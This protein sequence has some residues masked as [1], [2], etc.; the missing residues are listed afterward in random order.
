M[1]QTQKI[2]NYMALVKDYSKVLDLTSPKML[3]DFPIGIERSL[4][5]AHAIPPKARVLDLGSGAGLPAIPTAIWREDITIT[6]CE[7]RQ[8]R[9]A[10]LE[11]A[12]SLLE[13]PHATVFQGDVRR[14]Q[15]HFNVVTALWVGSLS[16]I[17][18]LVSAR[19]EPNWS[20]ISRK[21]SELEKEVKLLHQINPNI[22]I[23]TQQL[24]D[25]ATLVILRGG[26]QW[27]LK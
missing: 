4:P 26:H 23:E 27:Q 9:A 18:E 20:I 25:G 17:Y 2:S 6:L 22:E 16:Q 21:G 12:V 14:L 5:I 11:R 3:M 1:N 10:F 8:K 15:Q 24:E 19:L 13:L 7:I